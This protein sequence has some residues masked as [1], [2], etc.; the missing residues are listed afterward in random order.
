MKLTELNEQCDA[1]MGLYLYMHKANTALNEGGAL[2]RCT[3]PAKVMEDYIYENCNERQL[4]ELVI[5]KLRVHPL[6]GRDDNGDYSAQCI[7]PLVVDGKRVA[8]EYFTEVVEV[9]EVIWMK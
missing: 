3:T 2:Y 6:C 1:W 4:A 9:M 8:N 7:M 5:H